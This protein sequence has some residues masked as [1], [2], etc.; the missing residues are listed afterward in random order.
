VADFVVPS[1]SGLA[2]IPFA[3]KAR[4]YRAL[5]ELLDGGRPT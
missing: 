2:R 3:E 4:W 1:P 5:R